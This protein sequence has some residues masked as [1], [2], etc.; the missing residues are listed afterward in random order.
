MATN[1]ASNAEEVVK[2]II[3]GA[4]KAVAVLADVSRPE[5]IIKLFSITL[6]NLDRLDFVI[7]NSGKI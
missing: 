3:Q 2:E 5:E 7:S 4:R 6:G 1:R